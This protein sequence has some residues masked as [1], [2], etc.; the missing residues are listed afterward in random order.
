M[1]ADGN[2]LQ[3]MRKLNKLTPSEA[4]IAAFFEHNYPLAAF[5]T[6]ASIAE[7]VSVGK[8]TISRFIARLGYTN[9]PELMKS[10]QAEMIA[11]LESPAERYAKK[12]ELFTYNK[13]DQLALHISHAINNLQE[14]LQRISTDQFCQAAEAMAKCKGR[15]FVTGAATSQALADYFHLLAS[16]LRKDVYLVQANV[17]TLAH[18]IADVSS[19]DVLFA[20]THQ[21]LAKITVR[22]SRWFAKKKAKIIL[23]TDREITPISDI[24]AIQ[25][26]SCAHT[27]LMFSS[28]CSSFVLLEA[29]ITTMAIIL[30]Q[31][32]N[33][34]LAGFDDFFHEFKPFHE[35]VILQAQNQGQRKK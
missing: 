29:L 9:F 10:M 18:H 35:N 1:A 8:A 13:K 25:L 32:I 24:A 16:Y 5:E 12:R 11:R 15:L 19:N 26:V 6:I 30:E 33:E 7:K 3:R 2:L 17:G 28:R 23:H 4:K 20:L 22:I 14:T 31:K 21:R 34:R 27:P